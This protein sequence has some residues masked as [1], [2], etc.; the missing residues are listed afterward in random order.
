MKLD[1]LGCRGYWSDAFNRFDGLIVSAKCHVL[2]A[3]EPD[4]CDLG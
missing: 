2:S 1:A 3:S 4:G